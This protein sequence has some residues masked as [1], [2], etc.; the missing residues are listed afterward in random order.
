MKETL[1]LEPVLIW[2][3]LLNCDREA[4]S[5]FLALFEDSNGLSLLSDK[6]SDVKDKAKKVY[7]KSSSKEEPSFTDSDKKDN[8]SKRIEKTAFKIEESGLSNDALRAALWKRI[9]NV[10]RLESDGMMSPRDIKRYC[11]EIASIIINN[12]SSQLRKETESAIQKINPLKKRSS[13]FLS[14]ESAIEYLFAKITKEA[15]EQD[16]KIIKSI[17][18]EIYN[19]DTQILDQSGVSNLTD[20]AITKTLLTGGSLLGLMGG[21]QVAGFGAYI[22][23][24]QVS[25]IIPLV[26][27]KTLVSLLFVLANPFFVIPAIVATGA[28]SNKSLEKSIKQSFG[29]I[30]S[31]LLVMQGMIKKPMSCE[32][33]EFL[34]QYN[35]HIEIVYESGVLKIAPNHQ[36]ATIKAMLSDVSE[37]NIS[38]ADKN[39]LHSTI[40]IEKEDN[41]QVLKISSPSSQ[42]LDNVVIAGLTVSDFIYDI[43][44]IDPNV[45]E[46]TDFARKADI[47]D[48]F[49]FS[50]FSETLSSIS[51]AS[52]RGHHANLMGYTAERLVASRLVKDGHVV[53]IPSS[54][55]QPGYDLLVDGNEFQVKCIE[56]DNV[57]ILDKHF[58]K[59]PETP[60][61]VN[62]EMASV[63]EERVPEWAELVFYVGGYTHEKASGL[64]AQSIDAGQELDDYEILSSVALVSLVRNAIDWKRGEQSIQSA[65]FNIAVDSIS[66]GGMAIAGGIAGSGLGM[67]LFGPAGS[68]IIGGVSTVYGATQGNVITNRIDK[69]LDP[70]REVKLRSLS[71]SLLDRCN[72]ELLK[73]ITLLDKKISLL[74]N[75]GIS[76]Y[77]RYRFLWDKICFKI[78]IE[79]NKG[80]IIN[81][82]MPATK[83]IF[84]AIKLA[85]QST[86]HSYCLQKNYKEIAVAL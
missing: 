65:T 44:A 64:L 23:A 56:P 43:A 29:T 74:S 47:S 45:I 83:K 11:D 85:S 61:F 21:V 70:E 24:A 63:I 13:A 73:K 58:D 76:S 6:L 67:L 2:Y 75:D 28:I 51:E 32:S 57:H 71:N 86:V 37:P 9:L 49:E 33:E 17:E 38:V 62:S 66:K 34:K 40:K 78:S 53:E 16:D 80:L 36:S 77:I 84:K 10:L 8:F 5:I 82:S 15:I 25:A 60:V 59:Y 41:R 35:Q 42:N 3:G 4:L 14:F 20:I 27:G 55:S 81:E 79:R 22:M 1:K 19:L 50:I 46:A 31:T 18:K 69:F 54:A 12:A 26:G 48:V 52:L 30:I 39:L 68:Y 72:D 7:V